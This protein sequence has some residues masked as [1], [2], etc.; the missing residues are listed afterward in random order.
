MIIIIGERDGQTVVRIPSVTLNSN[1]FIIKEILF[2]SQI[3]QSK[4]G[5]L[6]E[7]GKKN[8]NRW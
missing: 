3:T 1:R 5:A 2:E 7:Q 4:Q 6:H 8:I